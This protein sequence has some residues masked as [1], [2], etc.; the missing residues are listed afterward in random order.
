V[1]V[2]IAEAKTP[3]QREAALDIRFRV[4]VDE[5]GISKDLELDDEDSRCLHVIAIAGGKTVGTA[6][7]YRAAD[8]EKS[9]KIGRMAVLREYREAGVGRAILEFL[10]SHARA[11]G[12]RR[13]I[14]HAQVQALE[15]YAKCGFIAE[16]SV[17]D[18]AGIPHQKMVRDL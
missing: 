18:E 3:A 15:F 16:G 14:L 17:F 9:V 11:E 8:S 1:R 13:A 4:F 2:E 5:Q 10:I 12:Y 6:R 7:M